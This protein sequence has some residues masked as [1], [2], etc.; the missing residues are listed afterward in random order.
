MRER[1]GVFEEIERQKERSARTTGK[2]TDQFALFVNWE[3]P[4]THTDIDIY[5]QGLLM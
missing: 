2:P 5:I 4:H 3:A 1:G